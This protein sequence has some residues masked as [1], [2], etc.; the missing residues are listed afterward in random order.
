MVFDQFTVGGAHWHLECPWAIN[1]TTHRSPLQPDAAVRA[2][3]LEPLLTAGQQRRCVKKRLNVVQYRRLLPQAVRPSSGRLFARLRPL[4]FQRLQQRTDLAADI[5]SGTHEQFQVKGKLRTTNALPE[6]ALAVVRGRV[7]SE[8][9]TS[10][11]A[12]V[13]NVSP[14]V[15]DGRYADC[16]DVLPNAA[17]GSPASTIAGV[18]A[19]ARGQAV[20]HGG[21][22]GAHREGR[23]TR[24]AAIRS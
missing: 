10:M 1:V 24:R 19:A 22:A 11:R 3:L 18:P 14:R 21:G 20:V 7:G 9:P 13:S 12:A 2:L 17:I 23:R 4:A 5:P 16:C 6:Y 8:Q 15:R